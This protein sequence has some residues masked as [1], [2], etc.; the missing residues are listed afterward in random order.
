MEKIQRKGIYGVYS[1]Y[2]TTGTRVLPAEAADIQSTKH[3]YPLVCCKV[4]PTGAPDW[5]SDHNTHQV[6]TF[7]RALNLKNFPCVETLHGVSHHMSGHVPNTP[8]SS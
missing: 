8:A 1:L 6:S 3:P 4:H 5:C 7:W 2:L